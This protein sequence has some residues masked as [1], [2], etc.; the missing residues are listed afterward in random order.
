MSTRGCVA[1]G[2]VKKWRGVY[3][4]SGSYPSGLGMELYEHL[5]RQML[6]GKTLAEIGESLLKF[7]DW[8]NYLE[9]GV[10]KYCGKM[11]GQPHSIRG[12]IVV[13]ADGGAKYPDPE[14]K[15]HQHNDISDDAA[16][17]TNQI[18]SD[19][20]DPLIIE[21]VYVIDSEANAIH[22]LAHESC[23]MVKLKKP[24]EL[25]P[26]G[27]TKEYVRKLSGGRFHYGHCVYKL[28]HVGTV[29]FDK[30][31]D[32]EAIECGDMYQHCG[33]Y[34]YHHFPELK[35]TP[36]EHLGT[37]EYISSEPLSGH[38]A[39]AAYIIKGEY[40]KKGGSGYQGRY[41]AQMGRF[42]CESDKWYQS[43]EGLDGRQGDAAVGQYVGKTMVPAPGVVW[44]F[45]PTLHHDWTSLPKIR[46]ERWEELKAKGVLVK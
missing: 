12:D 13:A 9:G 38:A 34:A 17:A 33:H 44:L 37:D 24:L 21:R 1:V 19:N 8:R 31:P 27:T 18:T 39:V 14:A 45:P 10:C 42:G 46:P 40:R 16:V 2:T 23:P 20:S 25:K 43:T 6:T 35:G 5:M 4:H 7:D 28:T 29:T 11:T 26:D 15:F 22:V 3:N 36:S 32:W 41:A 30:K